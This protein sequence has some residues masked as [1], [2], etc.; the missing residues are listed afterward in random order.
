MHFDVHWGFC[1]CSLVRGWGY[2]PYR[3]VRFLYCIGLVPYLTQQYLSEQFVPAC[4]MHWHLVHWNKSLFFNGSH[5]TL[6]YASVFTSVGFLSYAVGMSSSTISFIVSFSEKL[7]AMP[8]R[9]RFLSLIFFSD[10]VFFVEVDVFELLTICSILLPCAKIGVGWL[11][12]RE[13]TLLVYSLDVPAISIVLWL[14]DPVV[15]SADLDTNRCCV[16]ALLVTLCCAGGGVQDVS[17][18]IHDEGGRR[19]SAAS[20]SVCSFHSENSGSSPSSVLLTADLVALVGVFSSCLFLLRS[21]SGGTPDVV[22]AWYPSSFRACLKILSRD[23]EFG[24]F[25]DICCGLIG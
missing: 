2:F 16:A 18:A 5:F 8:L 3:N 4:Q 23:V 14:L 15:G 11:L 20:S 22:L 21:K 9:I 12:S 24:A 17:S 25:L 13:T 7:L 19:G 6:W 1:I 10:K